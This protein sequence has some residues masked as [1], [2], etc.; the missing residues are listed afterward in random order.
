MSDPFDMSR[1][2]RML[3]P[4][5]QEYQGLW[6]AI[7]VK[8]A[9]IDLASKRDNTNRG[10]ARS[11][12]ALMMGQRGIMCTFEIFLADGRTAMHIIQGNLNPWNGLQNI[13][14]K[15]FY[16][17]N[18]IHNATR[19]AVI[20]DE[21]DKHLIVNHKFYSIGSGNGGGFGGRTIRY[22][23]KTLGLG[24]MNYGPELETNDLWYS[25]PIP[26]AWRDRLPDNAVFVDGF[27]GPT[28]MY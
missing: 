26:P 4:D 7:L 9:E 19:L 15:T 22:K 13:S 6:A 24:K 23:F 25:G 2:S 16:S 21:P 18:D 17:D 5:S 1:K 27:D 14:V 11:G 8:V 3:D 28:V 10:T 20:T 12:G